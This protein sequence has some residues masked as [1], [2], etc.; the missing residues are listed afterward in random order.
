MKSTIL[1]VDDHEMML[2]GLKSILSVEKE[3]EVVGTVT[4]GRQAVETVRR[5][6]PDVVVMDIGMREL[7]GV[8]ATRQI[9]AAHPETKVVALSMFSDRRYVMA[10]L[11]AGASAYVVKLSAYNELRSAVRAVVSGK[12]YLSSEVVGAVIDEHRS[13]SARRAK[14]NASALAPREREVVQLLA[15]GYSSPQIASRL[16]ISPATVD[17]HR[18]NVM[19]KL[20]LHSVAELTKY[21]I[22]EGLTS[23]DG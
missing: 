9:K 13:R 8:E 7:S 17:S 16:Y 12:H 22:R 18:R 20:R 19:R 15:E 4:D 11:D 21:A 23:L 6:S 2:E 5:H 14:S 1:L 10:M 3:F